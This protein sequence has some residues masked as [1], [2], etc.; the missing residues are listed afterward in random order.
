MTVDAPSR[1]EQCIKMQVSSGTGKHAVLQ[2]VGFCGLHQGVALPSCAPSVV[3]PD[4][5]EPKYPVP[6]PNMTILY[7]C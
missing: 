6:V 4:P 3:P 1:C 5:R 2:L 7:A